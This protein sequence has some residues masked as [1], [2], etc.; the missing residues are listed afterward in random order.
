MTRVWHACFQRKNPQQ[1]FGRILHISPAAAVKSAR[2]PEQPEQH[3]DMIDANRLPWRNVFRSELDE[4]TIPC[5]LQT[6]GLNEN[7]LPPR[8]GG[9]RVERRSLHPAPAYPANIQASAPLRSQFPSAGQDTG[10]PSR[11]LR[12][13]GIG[14]PKL[15]RDPLHILEKPTRL[16]DGAAQIPQRRRAGILVLFRPFRPE[17]PGKPVRSTA[18][19]LRQHLEQGKSFQ[20]SPSSRMNRSNNHPLALAAATALF[21]HNSRQE[22]PIG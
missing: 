21:P 19:F 17:L 3:H 15:I 6:N 8:S 11:T 16:R 14:G 12:S 13:A 22:L 4:R 2:H 18:V 5:R 1:I 20:H 10:R 7:I 9:I